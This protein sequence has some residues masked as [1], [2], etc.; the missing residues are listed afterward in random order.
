[1]LSLKLQKMKDQLPDIFPEPQIERITMK[2]IGTAILAVLNLEKGI[3]YTLWVLFRTPGEAM[4]TYLF[5]DR[6][7][8]LDPVKLIIL[9]VAVYL[10]FLFNFVPDAGFIA[11]F[12]AG[13][14][15]GGSSPEG[16]QF[17]QDI[18]GFLQST[19]N[20][21]FLLSVPVAA[22]ASFWLLRSF[23]LKYTEHLVLNAFIYGFL[24]FVAILFIPFNIYSPTASQTILLGIFYLYMVYFFRDFLKI[25]WGK[26][27][28]KTALIFILGQI[29]Y[30]LFL[31][32]VMFIFL[33]V[34]LSLS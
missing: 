30:I 9:T 2:R 3:L 16:E 7:R 1:M 25:S 14:G 10:F 32:A 20:L 5:I 29:L 31:T 24:N 6:K 22:L 12:K 11:G 34:K 26:A 17:A 21:I 19:G 33:F 28:W 15:A 18:I 8:F 4:R 23:R 27:I 13:A